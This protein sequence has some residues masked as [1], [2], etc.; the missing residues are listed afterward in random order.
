[1]RLSEERY[2]NLS[3]V[4]WDYA[5]AYRYISDDE[6]QLEWVVGAFE[7]ITGHKP[8]DAQKDFQLD[9]WS[10]RTIRK[11]SGHA[12]TSCAPAR[13]TSAN[14]GLS[15]PVRK[16]AGCAVMG[17]PNGRN[18]SESDLRLYRRSGYR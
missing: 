12:I 3:S 13:M 8:E 4:L 17:D 5:C 10:T 6:A 14:F 15:T 18:A 7:E 9:T 2:R 11:F 16:S 1:M